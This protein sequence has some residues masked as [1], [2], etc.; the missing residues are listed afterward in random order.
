[1]K[2]NVVAFVVSTSNKI[3][4]YTDTFPELVADA[5]VT[6]KVDALAVATA[7][8]AVT[9]LP[10]VMV[11][12]SRSPAVKLFAMVTVITVVVCE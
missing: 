8:A 10:E 5:A 1:V 7:Y 9:A 2:E 12:H 3:D 6:V 4:E 11:Y